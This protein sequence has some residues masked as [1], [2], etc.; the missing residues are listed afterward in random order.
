MVSAPTNSSAAPPINCGG[1]LHE[2]QGQIA[3]PNINGTYT[4]NLNCE[5]VI[6]ANNTIDRIKIV[7]M[8][9]SVEYETSCRYD[10]VEIRNGGE[11]DSTFVGKYCGEIV[12]EVFI[13]SSNQLFIKLSTDYTVTKPGFLI[14]YQTGPISQLS[15]CESN[16]FNCSDSVTCIPTYMVCDGQQ[17]CVDGGDEESGFCETWTGKISC[18]SV[19]QE[20]EGQPASPNYP[21]D[22]PNDLDCKWVIRSND[23]SDRVKIMFQHFSVEYHAGCIYD[24]VEVYNGAEND[25]RIVGKYC[26]Q[27]VPQAFISSGNQLAIK[28]Y[29]DAY[30]TKSGFSISYQTGTISQLT[31]CDAN[32]FNC[33]D[34]SVLCIPP[35]M[36]CDGHQECTDG[37]DEDPTI[38]NN[39]QTCN[40]NEFTCA[41]GNPKCIPMSFKCDG[42]QDCLDGSD[43]ADEVC[44]HL[45]CPPDSVIE[46][47]Q[48][49]FTSPNHPGM[50]PNN[51]N[52]LWRIR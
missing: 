13:S 12:P 25:S 4:N 48:G 29:T 1:M 22:Y 32:T 5:W 40:D 10:Y 51:L 46:D 9:F 23:T 16:M 7:F 15:S 34:S 37:T 43:E 30:I 39:Y 2:S 19:V 47:N 27:D 31:T 45:T 11:S 33:S 38:C 36:I 35:F 18:G 14:S 17:D 6:R 26:G 52:C 21:A 8:N 28:L 49:N 41:S 42:Y 50:Y 44:G 3:S 20:R 24:Y